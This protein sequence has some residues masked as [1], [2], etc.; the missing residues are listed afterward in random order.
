MTGHKRSAAAAWDRRWAG[1]HLGWARL[2]CPLHLGCPCIYGVAGISAWRAAEM[3]VL[4]DSLA[5][6]EVCHSSRGQPYKVGCATR[7]GDFIWRCNG[8]RTCER[9][10]RTQV[11]GVWI[12][13]RHPKAESISNSPHHLFFSPQKQTRQ[14]PFCTLVAVE[15][16][17]DTSKTLPAPSH[18]TFFPSVLLCSPAAPSHST[19]SSASVF[20]PNFFFSAASSFASLSASIFCCIRVAW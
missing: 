12:A 4:R 3:Q 16:I 19:S 7:V 6:K 18:P 1:Q 8:E 13:R 17:A 14:G 11:E 5:K 20:T 9:G 10:R 2:G 15:L